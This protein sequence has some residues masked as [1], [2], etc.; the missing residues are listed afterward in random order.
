M[1]V[2]QPSMR[3]TIN[4]HNW[5]SRFIEKPVAQSYRMLDYD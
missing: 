2:I 4:S 3:G 1:I 5:S